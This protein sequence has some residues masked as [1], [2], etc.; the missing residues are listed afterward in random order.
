MNT[1]LLAEDEPVLG[2][3]VKEALERKGY[4]VNWATDG[5]A[6]F[7]QFRVNVPDICILDIMMPTLNGFVL[8]GKIRNISETV[9]IL[10]LTARSETS[11]VVKGFEVGG[12]DYLKKPFSLEELFLR[13]NELL[14][15]SLQTNP[16]LSQDLSKEKSNI[17]I[18]QFDPVGQTLKC[19]AETVTLSHKETMLL[20]ALIMHKNDLMPRR[21]ALMKIWGDDSFFNARTMDVYITKLRKY[22]H[23]DESVSIVNIRGLGFKLI[24]D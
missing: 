9:P 6:A 16:L 14:K 7:E 1:I 12:N 8:A 23:H 15:R 22:L 21:E 20:Q 11:D 24:A 2:K 10:F 17:G 13:V 18:Y 19:D 5:Q 4:Q 3:L